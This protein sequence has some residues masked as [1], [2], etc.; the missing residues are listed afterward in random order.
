MTELD[1]ATGALV[2]VIGASSYEFDFPAA[3]TSDG[4]HV[5]VA[6]GDSVTELDAATGA[7]VQVI[8]G[9]PYVGSTGRVR[10]PATAPTCGWPAVAL[11]MVVIR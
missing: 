4:T 3:I 1:A 6:G 5:W 11:L 2:Q 9:K 10:S 7:L 8:T